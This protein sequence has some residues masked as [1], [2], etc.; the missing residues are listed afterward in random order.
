MSSNMV[1]GTQ[2][3]GETAVAPWEL[4][5]CG[6]G[7]KKWGPGGHRNL[8]GSVVIH[9]DGTLVAERVGAAGEEAKLGQIIAGSASATAKPWWLGWGP[10]PRAGIPI[11]AVA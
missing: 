5:V 6:T 7:S 3:S 9:V 2:E 8:Q 4:Q 11:R 1:Y 10:I